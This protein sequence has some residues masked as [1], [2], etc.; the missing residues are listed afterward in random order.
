VFHIIDII[1][2]E[3]LRVVGGVIPF[4]RVSGG[5]KWRDRE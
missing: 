2:K 1:D 4:P 5:L 3:K